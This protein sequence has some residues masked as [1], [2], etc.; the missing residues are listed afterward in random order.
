MTPFFEGVRIL[1]AE[2]LTAKSSM[3]ICRAPNSEWYLKKH[4]FLLCLISRSVYFP[5]LSM[6]DG[7]EILRK[8]QWRLVVYP[9]IYRVLYIPGG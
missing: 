8:H 1:R 4:V 6:V 2:N 5:S 3:N 9:I 7:S